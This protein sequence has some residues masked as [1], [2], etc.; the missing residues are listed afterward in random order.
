[1]SLFVQLVQKRKLD[2]SNPS[3][4]PKKSSSSGPS[5]RKAR[6]DDDVS[7]DTGMGAASIYEGVGNTGI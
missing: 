3:P 2:K 7:V 4:A 6:L 1:M 5:K